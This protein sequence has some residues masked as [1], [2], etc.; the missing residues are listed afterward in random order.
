MASGQTGISN[1]RTRIFAGFFLLL[2]AATGFHAW[3]NMTVGTASQMGPGFFPLMLSIVL[4]ALSIIV[5]L[6][7]SDGPGRLKLPPAKALV[8]IL[9]APVIFALSIGPLGLVIT[10]AIVVLVTSFASRL[11]RLR[12]SLLL[13]GGLTVFCTVVFYY[14][15]SLPIPLWGTLITR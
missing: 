1:G 14:L 9:I 6:T 5:V 8:L 11:A 4:G 12:D 2:S 7:E 13:S 3:K 10:V 15:L